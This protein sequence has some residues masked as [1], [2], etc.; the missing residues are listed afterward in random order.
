MAN[1]RLNMSTRARV[2]A[3]LDDLLSRETNLHFDKFPV[4]DIMDF[5][6]S[7]LPPEI[8]DLA[9]V[10]PAQYSQILH[11]STVFAV[12]FTKPRDIGSK[13]RQYVVS[14]RTPSAVLS[15]ARPAWGLSAKDAFPLTGPYAEVL[16]SWIIE[17]QTITDRKQRTL[18]AAH[19]ALKRMQSV[20]QMNTVLVE[21]VP[22]LPDSLRELS[23]KGTSRVDPFRYLDEDSRER[24]NERL[25]DM[26]QSITRCILLPHSVDR[27]P[28]FN[29]KIEDSE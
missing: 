28:P 15:L 7:T 23:Q 17:L 26:H 21:L 1:P 27:V 16:S 29:L 5:Y 2:I 24:M 18:N 22:L 12:R 13:L 19:A 20:Y 3:T 25:R 14:F 4:L 8:R 10:V 6:H 11:T 9:K